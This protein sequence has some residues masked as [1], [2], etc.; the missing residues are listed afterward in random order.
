MPSIG[1]PARHF[2][3]PNGGVVVYGDMRQFF[4]AIASHMEMAGEFKDHAFI[5]VHG[6][7]T[8][9]EFALFRTAQLAFDIGSDGAPFGTSFL[10]S[11]P[12]RG[13]LGSYAYD[14]DS[15]RLSAEQLS[16]FIEAIIEKTG[17]KHLHIIAHSMGNWP[18]LVALDYVGR[19]DENRAKLGQVVLAAPD[20]D[21][22]EFTRMVARVLPAAKGM[23]LYVSSND[24]AMIA[25]RML[26]NDTYRAGDVAPDGPV[27]LPGVD[28]IDLSLIHI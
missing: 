12:S 25:S 10:F 13:T 7:N 19:S 11:W 2:T 17:A 3:I 21:A 9:F 6:A 26:R 8:S 22:E 24:T 20:V 4:N 14:L 27:V 5:F 15:A 16:K 28:T 18:A 23:T 1:D